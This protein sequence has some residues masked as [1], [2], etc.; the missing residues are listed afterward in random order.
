[1]SG[2][3]ARGVLEIRFIHTM[4]VAQVVK[5]I[6]VATGLPI[7]EIRDGVTRGTSL[8]VCRR[9]ACG[10][11]ESTAGAF[12]LIDE[13]ARIGA[14]FE[15]FV[16]GHIR[17]RQFLENTADR[18]RQ[19]RAETEIEMDLESGEPC[20][21]TLEYL[22]RHWPPDIFRKTLECIVRGDGFSVDAETLQWTKQELGTN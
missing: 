2:N 12:A 13:L 3:D 10:Q 16:G 1:V 4:N 20:I 14:R 7:V 8:Q 19:N 6:R 15:I 18:D 22:K 21:E 17:T 9:F 11:E 5:A